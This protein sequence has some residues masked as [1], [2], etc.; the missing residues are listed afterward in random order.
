MAYSNVSKPSFYIPYFDYYA[1][2]GGGHSQP[3]TPLGGNPFYLNPTNFNIYPVELGEG[4]AAST[5]LNFDE[6]HAPSYDSIADSDDW[7]YIFVLG[8]NFHEKNI[9]FNP[10]LYQSIVNYEGGETAPGANGFSIFR[11]KWNAAYFDE[12]GEDILGF[13]F[14]MDAVTGTENPA[15]GCVSICS[16]WTPPHSPDLSLKMSREFDGNKTIETIGGATLSNSKFNQPASWGMWKAWELSHASYNPDHSPPYSQRTLGRRTWDLNFSYISDS[17]LMPASESLNFYDTVDPDGTL[18]TNDSNF[19]GA[20]SFYKTGTNI[21]E[22][23][24]FLA[25]VANR[26]QGSH[27][28]FIFQPDSTNTNPDQ[29]AICRFDQDSFVMEQVANN[30]YNIELKIRECW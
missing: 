5:T 9:G 3:T 26:V 24:T 19:Q 29:W 25:R 18:Y 14:I 22:S 4:M 27:V 2:T 10:I 21:Q 11:A 23:Q 16:K 8:H 28:P 1:T 15:L 20:N 12:S 30:V 7:I 17:D 6:H 13:K